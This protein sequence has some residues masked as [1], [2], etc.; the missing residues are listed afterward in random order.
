[1]SRYQK[2]IGG[3]LDTETNLIWKE[4]P[5]EGSFTFDEALEL[6]TDGWRLPTIKELEGIV[7]YEKYNPATTL[8]NQARSIVWSSSPYADTTGYAW[9]LVFRYGYANYGSQGYSLQV[10]LVRD[11]KIEKI[12]PCPCGKTPERIL[13]L[14]GSTSTYGF[15]VGDCCTEWHVEF[16]TQHKPESG[17]RDALALKAWNGAPR[18][19]R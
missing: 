6:Q 1:M 7:D 14:P 4:F 18:G 13:C 2:V 8:P 17:E 12:K 19:E 15:A 5:E 11:T 9:Y 3:F 16:H 10:H